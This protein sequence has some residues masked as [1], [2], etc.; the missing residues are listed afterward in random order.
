MLTTKFGR[1]YRSNTIRFNKKV[2]M[3]RDELF[4]HIK[5]NE[6]NTITNAYSNWD[7]FK[8]ENKDNGKFSL[9]GT[10]LSKLTL[11]NEV[12]DNPCNHSEHTVW[13]EWY[14]TGGGWT[15]DNYVREV[16]SNCGEPLSKWKER[17]I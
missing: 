17:Y 7:E 3:R 15:S 13:K 11:S 9:L 2:L 6:G 16:C 1:Q 4:C 10:L 5:D 14:C 8:K 12:P